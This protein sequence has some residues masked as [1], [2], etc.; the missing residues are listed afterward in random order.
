LDE[1]LQKAVSRRLESDVPLGC[2]LSGGIDSGL[3]T[4]IASRHLDKPINT[5]SVGFTS[6]RTRDNEIPLARLV[7]QKYGTCHKELIVNQDIRT[8]LPEMMWS[9]GEPFA[10]VSIIPTY[11]M[12]RTAKEFITVALSGDGGDE[13]FAGYMHIQAAY[14]AKQL[15][16][17]VPAKLL[18]KFK[19]LTDGRLI[20]FQRINTLLTYATRPALQVYNLPNWFNISSRHC[21]YHPDWL[22]GRPA[23]NHLETIAQNLEKVKDLEEAE[24]MLYNDYHWVLPGDYLTKVDVAS[25]KVAIE[26]RS[27]FLDHELVEFAN[28]IPIEIRLFRFQQKG[29]LRRLA[30]KYLPEELLHQPKRG[31]SP[32]LEQWLRQEL[33]SLTR[34]L[35]CDSLALRPGIFNPTALKTIVEE[36]IS[37]KANHANRLWALICLEVWWQIFVD[38]TLT[39]GA[40]LADHYQ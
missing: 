17:F 3:I 14:L 23:I 29:L 22:N 16:R 10:D 11:L 40:S 5:F 30:T 4:A 15:K 19:R 39:P 36:H 37:G 12:C 35:I 28:N 8:L 1:R 13:S 31:F 24:Q 25:S 7:A 20:G 6:A 34:S 27:P 18:N 21:L 33:S 38:K 2:F 32:P 9:C 26:I